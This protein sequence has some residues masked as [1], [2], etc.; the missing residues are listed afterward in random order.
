LLGTATVPRFD[1]CDLDRGQHILAC[2]GGGGV[3]RLQLHPGAAPTVIDTTTI[4]PG[5]HT[6]AVDPS[7]H[8]IFAVWSRRDGSGDFFQKFVP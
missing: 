1:Q 7:T 5:V 4:D 3:T 2:A 6:T 8:G